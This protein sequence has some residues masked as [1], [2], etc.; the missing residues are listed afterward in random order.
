[1]YLGPE[2][3]A[4]SRDC[5]ARASPFFRDLCTAPIPRDLWGPCVE[6]LSGDAGRDS[7]IEQ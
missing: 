5:K 4:P 1:M 6:G 3:S 2:G 7:R